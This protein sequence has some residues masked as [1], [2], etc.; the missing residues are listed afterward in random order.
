ML[1][2]LTV[3]VTFSGPSEVAVENA[4]APVD[5]WPSAFVPLVRLAWAPWPGPPLSCTRTWAPFGTFVRC[6]LTPKLRAVVVN[7]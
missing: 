2:C 6:T 3:T 5:H 4:D 1:P 7:G